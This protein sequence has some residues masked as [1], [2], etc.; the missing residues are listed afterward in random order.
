MITVKMVSGF[1]DRIAPYSTK[2]E[3]DNC[4]LLVGNAD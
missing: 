2:C 3:W 1:I 4:G